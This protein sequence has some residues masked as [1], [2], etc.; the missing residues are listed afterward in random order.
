MGCTHEEATLAWLYGEGEEGALAHVAGCEACQ[1]LVEAHEAVLA[2]VYVAQ[3]RKAR[4]MRPRVGRWAVG[5]LLAAVALLGV[6]LWLGG[7]REVV[8]ASEPLLAELAPRGEL[9]ARLDDLDDAMDD[10][11]DDLEEL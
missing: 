10:L 6:G 4:V 3:P 5:L 9:D 1:A 2:A 11:F 7:P 8:P